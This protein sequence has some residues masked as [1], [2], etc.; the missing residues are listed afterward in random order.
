MP[1]SF[2]QASLVPL[3]N[4]GS[5]VDPRNYRLI[6]LLSHLRKVI[7][8]ALDIRIRRVHFFHP[9]QLG[10]QNGKGT[11]AAILRKN[12]MRLGKLCMAVLDLKAAYH[13]VPRDKLMELVSAAL[14]KELANMVYLTLEPGTVSTVFDEKSTRLTIEKG[15]PQGSPLSPCIFNI[16]MD[17]LASRLC[18]ERQRVDKWPITLFADDVKYSAATPGALQALLIAASS[19]AK[20]HGM[21]WNTD[22][23][24]LLRNNFT[25]NHQFYLAGM[26]I[27]LAEAADYL[28]ITLI[29][30]RVTDDKN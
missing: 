26:E 12:S 11:E 7:E 14:S 9:A 24:W 6:A 23:S 15:M 4:K 8:T 27:A 16:F 1:A 30:T 28:D 25:E 13:S 29:G 10:F 2:R 21:T 5:P 20:E 22:K 18:H 17:S 3:F 19:W